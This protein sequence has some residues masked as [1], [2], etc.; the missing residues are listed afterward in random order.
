M[1]V[2]LKKTNIF[3]VYP[4]IWF[5]VFSDYLKSIG[6][7][8]LISYEQQENKYFFNKIQDN[9]FLDFSHILFYL[10]AFDYLI[11]QHRG[12]LIGSF[13]YDTKN[14]HILYYVF[15]K[16]QNIFDISLSLDRQKYN[17]YTF[18]HKIVNK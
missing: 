1:F 9:E 15:K 17:D 2:T 12:Q 8:R 11:P 6:N 5:Y 4:E 13:C 14:V 7:N 18:N 16:Y 10:K 3:Y